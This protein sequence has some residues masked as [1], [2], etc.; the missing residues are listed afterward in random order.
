M[1]GK[2]ST[3]TM[4]SGF[5]VSHS[6]DRTNLMPD[7]VSRIW[8]VDLVVQEKFWGWTAFKVFDQQGAQLLEVQKTVS[9][10]CQL[11]IVD[12]K[13]RGVAVLM[14]KVL[15]LRLTYLVYGFVPREPGQAPSGEQFEG[16]DLY[17]WAMVE[18]PFECTTRPSIVG[19]M[20]T[21]DGS[22]T[23]GSYRLKP[24]SWF[25]PKLQIT[26]DDKGC[27][28]VDRSLLQLDCANCYA[29]KIA[30]GVD[31]G[32]MVCFVIIKDELMGVEGRGAN[33]HANCGN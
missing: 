33:N 29:L 2:Q 21:A 12:P 16:Q 14:R 25:S 28:Y 6:Q 15:S 30:P 26:K 4:P 8:P 9:L 13:G 10:R 1:G 32:L 17:S 20:A 18:K 24:V 23:A 3:D 5:L 27:C 31:P 19:S 11:N 7:L 22:W